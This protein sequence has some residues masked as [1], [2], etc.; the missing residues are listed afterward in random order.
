MPSLP[1][2]QIQRQE[3]PG[4]DRRQ[5]HGGRC[6]E[7]REGWKEQARMIAGVAATGG[8]ERR[9]GLWRSAAPVVSMSNVLSLNLIFPY[10]APMC[11]SPQ[12]HSYPLG[13]ALH[14]S[15]VLSPLCPGL[16]CLQFVRILTFNCTYGCIH[17]CMCTYICVLGSLTPTPSYHTIYRGAENSWRLLKA[18]TSL[19]RY[20]DLSPCIPP[21]SSSHRIIARCCCCCC[22]CSPHL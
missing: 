16:H 17:V 11:V 13:A 10:A 15:V 3:A 21:L 7:V 1:Y 2:P 18:T 22:C 9:E 20:H 14:C 6:A 12:Q 8:R 4:S 19:A 5:T